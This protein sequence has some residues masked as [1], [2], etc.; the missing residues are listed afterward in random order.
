MPENGGQDL[1]AVL[2]KLGRMEHLLGTLLNK[3]QNP[4]A[5]K[6]ADE[7]L[8]LLARGLK[9]N[10]VIAYRGRAKN[11]IEFVGFKQVYTREDVLAFLDYRRAQGIKDI[12][13]DFDVLRRLF[14]RL[15]L[16]WEF[17]REE[18][19]K[20]ISPRRP[21]YTEA[22]LRHLL[23]CSSS[24][25]NIYRYDGRHRRT[26]LRDHAM[27]RVAVILGVRKNELRKLNRSDFRPPLLYIST[28][29]GGESLWRT[30]DPETIRIIK[31]YL[32]ARTDDHPALFVSSRSKRLAAST[33][34]YVQARMKQAAGINIPRAGW[35]AIRRG[36]TTLEHN[37][38]MSETELMAIRGWKTREMPSIYCRLMPAEVEKKAQRINPFFK[39]SR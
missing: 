14:K 3:R 37:G 34:D 35:H 31:K 25:K 8:A 12:R 28:S 23:K 32:A 21:F 4:L 30:L 27:F 9:E 18:I 6:S 17:E 19:P 13:G 20:K 24:R 16:P 38:G 33:L 7:Q 5:V 36:V 26:R 29:K 22:D 10:S 11:F 1:Q 15:G 2:D 39:N